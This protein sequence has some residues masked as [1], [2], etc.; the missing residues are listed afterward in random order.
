MPG[1]VASFS[2]PMRNDVSWGSTHCALVSDLPRKNITPDK[3]R[4]G[5]HSPFHNHVLPFSFYISGL[6]ETSIDRAGIIRALAKSR[7]KSARQ[8]EKHM[9]GELRG[10]SRRITWPHF[11]RLPSSYFR[12]WRKPPEIPEE[13]RT[14]AG[15]R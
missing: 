1:N 7:L 6:S 9:Q 5:K 8:A 10:T 11:N 4:T 3:K 12:S 15:S 14:A 13:F 2:V